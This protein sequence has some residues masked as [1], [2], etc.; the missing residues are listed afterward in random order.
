MNALR[1][2]LTALSTPVEECRHFF[3]C[4]IDGQLRR[5]SG[6]GCRIDGHG[7]FSDYAEMKHR[8]VKFRGEPKTMPYET[9]SR[10]KTCTAIRS[11][12]TRIPFENE[13]Q[14]SAIDAR[15]SIGSADSFGPRAKSVKSRCFDVCEEL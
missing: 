3:A 12:S 8:G 14:L 1:A 10:Y 13:F 11:I 5:P 7:A 6:R 4:F 15:S 2:P 9:G